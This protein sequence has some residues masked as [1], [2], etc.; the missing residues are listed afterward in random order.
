M[1]TAGRLRFRATAMRPSA[2]RDTVG[3]PVRTFTD[4]GKLWVDLE[5]QAA[6]ETEWGGGQAV[7]R[8]FLVSARWARVK[9]LGLDET[10][11]LRVRGRELRIIAVRNVREKDFLAEIDA[12]EVDE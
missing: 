10:W 12:T 3:H 5:D 9:E 1:I 2:S 6:S 11:R 4:A 8:T 7:T